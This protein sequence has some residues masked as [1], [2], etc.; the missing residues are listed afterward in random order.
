MEILSGIKI[1]LDIADTVYSFVKKSSDTDKEAAL[2][3]LT[4]IGN[5]L[6]EVAI[7]LDQSRYPHEK[8]AMMFE[9]MHGLK[10]VLKGQMS[11][12]EVNRLQ[13]MIEESYR[14][15]QLLGQLNQLP[16]MERSFNINMI[17]AAAGSFWGVSKL[18][19]V[20]AV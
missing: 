4:D 3:V 12:D 1:F 11:E 6:Q 13:N 5:L 15:E 9:Y 10:K 8:C 19:K 20:G 18:I 17:R 7:E 14:V 16:E 2:Q